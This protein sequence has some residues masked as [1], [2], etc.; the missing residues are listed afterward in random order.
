[1]TVTGESL[2]PPAFGVGETEAAMTGGPGAVTLMLA[3][4]VRPLA[5]TE[6]VAMPGLTA[7]TTPVELTVA[8]F[9]AEELQDALA[10]IS[11]EVPSE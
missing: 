7:V 5:E 11:R 9:D 3:T 1:V 2:Q 4:N 10:V 8:M 6:I